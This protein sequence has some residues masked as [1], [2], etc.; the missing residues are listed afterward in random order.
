M[1]SY[2]HLE[3]LIG[4]WF[5]QDYDIEGDTLEEVIAAYR[6]G[7]TAADRIGTRADIHKFLQHYDDESL[8]EEFVRVFNSDIIPDPGG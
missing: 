6:K 1:D 3:N 8:K 7:T 4:C 5:H 2:P